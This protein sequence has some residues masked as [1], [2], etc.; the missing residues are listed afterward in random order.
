A[1]LLSAQ[2]VQSAPVGLATAITAASAA[3][4]ILPATSTL[5]IVMT[6]TKAKIGLAAVLA[7]SVTTPLVL[8][9][10]KRTRARRRNSD[11]AVSIPELASARERGFILP[12]SRRGLAPSSTIR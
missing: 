9:H 8:Q 6:S 11:G 4:T 5:Q 7:A 3:N 1:G 10:P 12:R 2:A